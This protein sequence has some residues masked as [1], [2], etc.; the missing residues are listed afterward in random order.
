M[1]TVERKTLIKSSFNNIADEY[2]GDAL[3]FFHLGGRF[4]VE[5]LALTGGE[6]VL[7]LATGTGAVAIEAAKQLP[8]GRV[9]A[10]DF[11]IAMLSKARKKAELRKLNNIE[12]KCRD[13]EVLDYDSRFDVVSMGFAIFFMPDMIKTVTRMAQWAKPGG[14]LAL[15]SFSN[16]S[17]SPLIDFFQNEL[18]AWGIS[19]LEPTWKCLQEEALYKRLFK[20]AGLNSPMVFQQDISYH[21]KDENQWWEIIWGSG[22]RGLVNQL[23][24]ND[25]QEF[26]KQHLAKVRRYVIDENRPLNVGVLLGLTQV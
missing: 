21:L 5:K 14:K 26:K 25:L 12:F 8:K 1:D 2:D 24:A 3:R 9:E 11:S 19:G 22:L 7:D 4:L 6:N 20:A 23:P 15:C 17:F 16:G 10:V 18:R 13:I